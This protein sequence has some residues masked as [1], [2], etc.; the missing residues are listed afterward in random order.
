MPQSVIDVTL[1][2]IVG[3]RRVAEIQITTGR[4]IFLQQRQPSR[5]LAVFAAGERERRQ[6]MRIRETEK[7]QF[8]RS[9]HID[10]EWVQERYLETPSAVC[11]KVDA[12]D[13]RE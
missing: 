6:C 8:C 2:G 11:W 13:R 7:G 5:C 10:I 4:D 12:A 9:T 1:Y 3:K